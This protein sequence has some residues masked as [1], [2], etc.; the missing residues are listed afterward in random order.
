MS[1]QI[2]ICAGANE[3]YMIG[4]TA[5]FSG[6]ALNA[7]PTTLLRF[8][9]FTENVKPES[10]VFMRKILTRIHEQ[11]EIIEHP[12]D[13]QL[14]AGLPYWAGS[15]LSAA[16]VLYPYLLK[17]LDWAL[18]VDCD[19]LYFASPE[20]HF[21]FRNPNSYVCVTQEE[22]EFTRRRECLWAKQ[23]CK[24]DIPDDEYFNAGIMLFNLKKCREDKIPEKI[25]QFYKYYPDVALPDQSAMNV[26][27]N[28]GKTMLP[29]KYDRLQ[30]YISD[31]KLQERPVL[32]FVSGNPWLPKLGVV[33]NG[34]FRLWH[35]YC[36]KYIWQNDGESY[37]RC[38]TRKLLSMKYILY[39]LL[40]MPVVGTL[41][42]RL[43]QTIGFT[44]NGMV[45][46]DQQL[47]HDCSDKAISK[48]LN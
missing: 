5:A 30:I 16:R 43:L 40:R 20:E 4:A 26:I 7:K 19:V 11:I 44:G 14:L 38:F 41:S 36:D 46:R 29:G 42:A 1:D 13:E 39:N 23:R 12:C 37:R 34:R 6:I 48:I 8:H 9:I 35:R 45:W 17:E 31:A 22:D 21:S 2:D 15:R 24:V 3:R 25:L 33:A 27:F 28:G 32:H 18:Y 10:V 47:S